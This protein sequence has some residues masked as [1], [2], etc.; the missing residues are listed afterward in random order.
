MTDLLQFTINVRKSDI[1]TQRTVQ[2][3]CE[4]RFF[5]IS[6]ELIFTSLCAGSSIQNA[7]EQFDWCIHLSFVNFAL[8][9]TPLT[10]I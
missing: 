8:H 9:P 5:F 4:Y 3:V 10:K 7:S 1:Q 2:L 6:S